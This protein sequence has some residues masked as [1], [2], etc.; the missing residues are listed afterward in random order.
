MISIVLKCLELRLVVQLGSKFKSR[1][2]KSVKYI[3]YIHSSNK[4]IFSLN[5]R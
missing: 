2:F 5:L 1:I 4:F 3:K